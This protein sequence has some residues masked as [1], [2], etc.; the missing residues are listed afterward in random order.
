MWE[1]TVLLVFGWVA[2]VAHLAGIVHAVHA[3]MRVRTPQGSIAWAISLVTFPYLAIP[4]YWIFGR[5]R[6]AGYVKARRAGNLKINH[7]ADKLISQMLDHRVDPGTRH[8]AL[9]VLEKLA[10]LP[11]TRG[12][13]ARLLIDGDATFDAIFAAI[14]HARHYLLVQFFIVHDDR[15]GRELKARLLE[16]A[17]AGVKIYFLYD[18]VGS[19][20]LPSAY[21]DELRAAGVAI[22]PFKTTRGRRNRFQ[23]NFRNHRKIVVADGKR[24]FIGGLNVGD[25]YMGRS[26]RF[27]PWRDTHLT[28]E[29]PAVQGIQLIF[30]EDW[31][32][33]AQETLALAWVPTQSAGGDQSALVI[34]AG[35][36][37]ELETCNLFFVHVIHMARQRLWITSP[38]FVP[39]LGVLNALQLAALRGVD[40]RI[41]LPEKPDHL[42]VYLSSFA[43]L[44]AMERA[45][46]K[47]FR[48]Q[49]G[50]LHQKALLVDDDLAAIG[51]ANLDNRSFRLNFELLVLLADRGFADQVRDML[52]RDFTH[53]RPARGRDY[54]KRPAA[55]RLAVQIARLMSPVQ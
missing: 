21:V 1:H 10:R 7:L 17:R 55:F 47:I 30:Q 29:G 45:G 25:E 11:A 4:L 12:N 19:H 28:I 13:H 37:D 51:T 15:L 5:S 50:F 23:I 48:Y 38:Y 16:C 40:V 31:Y 53:C 18:E 36:A 42:L 39:D 32:W 3:I 44:P 52:E 46:V 49:P 34:P 2:P 9:P 41:M 35:P 6:F 26:A 20:D 27:G 24:A 54:E 22:R 43:Y 8:P 33:A 14:A